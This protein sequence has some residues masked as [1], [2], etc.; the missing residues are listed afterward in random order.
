MGEPVMRRIHLLTDEAQ[1]WVEAHVKCRQ[2]YILNICFY[3]RIQ[4]K[5]EMKPH[6]P[7]I[8]KLLD[9]RQLLKKYAI[10]DPKSLEELDRIAKMNIVPL[11]PPLPPKGIRNNIPMKMRDKAPMMMTDT[12]VDSEREDEDSIS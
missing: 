10:I 11:P 1:K 12:D 7:I 5:G 2:Q 3:L 6:H 8:K 4:G 9:L